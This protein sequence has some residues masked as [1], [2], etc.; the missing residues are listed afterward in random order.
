MRTSR[1]LLLSICALFLAAATGCGTPGAPLPPSLGLPSPVEDLTASRKGS[2]VV[3]TWSPSQRTTDKQNIKH[4]GVTRI[5]RVAGQLSITQCTTVVAEIPPAKVPAPTDQQPRPKLIYEDVLPET[6]FSANAFATYAVEMLN[7][8]GRSAGLSNQ[9]RVPLAP[10]MP[11][12]TNLQANVTADGVSLTWTA[13]TQ[14]STST[15]VRYHY[16]L[17]RRTAGKGQFTVIEDVPAGG[18]EM[19][20]ADKNFEWEQ[21]YEYKVSPLTDVLDNGQ[22]VAEVEGED[23]PIVKVFVHDTFPPAQ[24]NGVQA[25]FSGA[26][27]KPFIDLSWAPNTE[28]DV[29]GYDIF[30]HEEGAQLVKINTEP[31][32][33]PAYRDENVETGKKYFYAVRAVDIRNNAGPI[34]EETSESVPLE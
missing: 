15:D 13:S 3:L 29:A 22:Q 24:V 30:R 34:S 16:H 26:G 14:A 2:R 25:V 4:P 7:S 17:L 6:V 33:A 11:P 23:S 1:L 5:C 10:T 32:K 27:Q 19:R 8:S 18:R 21:S 20:V 12:V 28:S 31:V 9:V